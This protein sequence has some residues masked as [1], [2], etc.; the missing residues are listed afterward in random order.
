MKKNITNWLNEFEFLIKEN[1]TFILS[2]WNNVSAVCGCLNNWKTNGWRSEFVVCSTDVESVD[3]F[4]SSAKK[5]IWKGVQL[6]D[7]L[8]GACNRI[9]FTPPLGTVIEE[10]ENSNPQELWEISFNCETDIGSKEKIWTVEIWVES[11]FFQGEVLAASNR[12]VQLIHVVY[13][14]AEE[15]KR[16]ALAGQAP[17]EITLTMRINF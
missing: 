2:K 7:K 5:L 12:G 16:L 15:R 4:P 14:I 11:D 1:K 8:L 17:S 3:D 10:I 9:N 6:G 13:S